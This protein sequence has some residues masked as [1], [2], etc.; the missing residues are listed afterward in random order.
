VGGTPTVKKIGKDASVAALFAIGGWLTSEDGPLHDSSPATKRLVNSV[1]G[2]PLLAKLEGPELLKTLGK[3]EDLPDFVMHGLTTAIGVLGASTNDR[4]MINSAAMLAT[5]FSMAGHLEDGVAMKSLEGVEKL[6]AI[7]PKEA[8]LHGV[9]KMVPVGDVKVGDIIHVKAGEV[10]PVDAD[11]LHMNLHGVKTELGAVT[12]PAVLNGEMNPISV[13][14]STG[15]PQGAVVA[16]GHDMVLKV[17]KLEHEST[18]SQNVKYLQDAEKV[19]SKAAHSI[20]SGIRNIYVPIMLAALPLAW[21][22]S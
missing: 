2:V 9:D 21:L 7:V 22:P 14:H 1:F 18:I 13:T 16:E 17:T 6:E 11:V 4:D 3:R 15:V 12:P 10:I 5:L 8:R 19:P 20:H